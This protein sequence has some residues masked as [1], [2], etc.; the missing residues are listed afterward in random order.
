[1][2]TKINHL[3][4][5]TCVIIFFGLGFTWYG[6]LFGT[7]WMTLAHIDLDAARSDPP[8]A[9]V[10]I[11]NLIGTVIPLYILAWLF[12]KLNVT[13]GVQ[14]AGIALLIVF[15]F[16]HLPSMVSN[17]FAQQPYGLAWI[18]G[19][20]EMAGMTIS[21]FILGAWRKPGNPS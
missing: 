16:H 17:M 6:P 11:S 7:Q 15:G 2:D 19:G 20:F 14:G 8:G 18:T 5:L 10:W 13:S 4:V 21:G 3:A 9:G 1:M 12:T